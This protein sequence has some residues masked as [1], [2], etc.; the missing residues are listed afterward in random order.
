V[1]PPLRMWVGAGMTAF[2]YGACWHPRRRLRSLEVAF[3]ERATPAEEFEM[4]RLDVYDEAERSRLQALDPYGHSISSQPAGVGSTRAPHRRALPYRSGFWA[5]V[6][7]SDAGEAHDGSLSVRACLEGNGAAEAELAPL[8]VLAGADLDPVPVARPVMAPVV[9]ICMA[10]FNP[11]LAQFEVQIRSI[12]VQT[13]PGWICVI[14]DDDSPEEIQRRMVAVIGDDPRF[15]FCAHRRRVGFYRNFERALAAVPTEADYVAL[16]D[17]DDRWYPEKLERLI[18]GIGA[19]RLVFSDVRIVGSSGALI[20]ET[21]FDHRPNNTTALDRLLLM[22]TVT[23]AASLFPRELLQLALPFPPPIGPRAFHDQWIAAVALA[24]GSIRFLSEPLYDYVQHGGSVLGHPSS[25]VTAESGAV[26]E[27]AS[28][29]VFGQRERYFGDLC[30]LRVVAGTLLLRCGGRMTPDKQRAVSRLLR[31]RSPLTLAKLSARSLR[32]R[33][34]SP[35]FGE[36]RRILRA[37]VWPAAVRAASRTRRFRDLDAR[38]PDAI[39][40]ALEP[41]LQPPPGIAELRRKTEPLKLDVCDGERPRVN[42][43]IPGI[44]LRGFFGGYIG[45]FNLAR[46]LRLEGFRVRIV[47]FELPNDARRLPSDWRAQVERFSGLEGTFDRVD[48]DAGPA[49]DQPLRVSPRDRFVATTWWSAHVAAAASR[50]LGRERFLYVVQDYE[51]LFYPMGTWHAL[52]EQSYD[53]PHYALF[54]SDLL[55]GYFRERKLGVYAAGAEDGNASSAAFSNA[56]TPVTPPTVVELAARKRRRLLIYARLETYSPRNLFDLGILALI[57][58]IAD[59]TLDDRWDLYGIGSV[60]GPARFDLG[61]GRE[62][63]LTPRQPEG[64][65]ADFLRR[66]DLGLSLM[67]SPHP[68]LVPLEMAAAGM[69]TVTN[70]YRNKTR[71]AMAEISPNLIA[72]PPNREGLREALREAIAGVENFDRRIDGAAIRWPTG[73]DEALEDDLIATLEGFLRAS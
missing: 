66:H 63:V 23:G 56:I 52:A 7:F 44:D 39:R 15:V 9:A 20:S 14:S 6:D 17:Q 26:R 37:V 27:R 33:A 71:S 34:S 25:Y 61:G 2:V 32:P 30:R 48:V 10:T 57:D 49:E 46:R 35:S 55:R 3:A 19:H 36:E 72:G 62:L 45:I 42:V 59:G 70:S 41:R 69:L 1:G 29:L 4:P 51:P 47:C 67:H 58:L 13:H 64:L 65:Y 18:D 53:F 50:A 73:W 40:D 22:N 60:G 12:Q 11:D 54:S 5:F 43:L 68:S 38:I 16:A 24:T 8:T 31:P 28:Q 21:F